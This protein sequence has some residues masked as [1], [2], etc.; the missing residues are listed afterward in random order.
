MIELDQLS[1]KFGDYTAVNALSFQAKPGEIL[2]FLGPNGAGK[3]TT[4]KMI[5]GALTPTSGRAIMAGHDI[6]L[7]TLQAQKHIG[8]LPEGA[9]AWA[10]M[11]PDKMLGFFASVR[12]LDGKAMERARDFAIERANLQGV[13]HQ[14]IDTLS[15]GFKRR[16][17]LAGAILHDPDILILDEPTDGLDPNQKFEVRQLIADLSNEKAIVIS[18]HILEEVDAICNRAMII[19]QGRLIADG[20]PQSLL[21]K[22]PKHLQIGL[23]TNLTHAQLK[24]ALQGLTGIK[25][26]EGSGDWTYVSPSESQDLR[27]AMKAH[28]EAR[29]VVIMEMHIMQGRMDDVFRLLT[30]DVN[31][32]QAA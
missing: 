26:V 32:D 13:R 31:K 22:D 17:G 12:G 20:T 23:K 4:M 11:T 10:D 1:K 5:T 8:Y 27:D 16:V 2:G 15:K 30:Q 7:E 28:L 29:E 19:N 14:L 18:T 21:E 25:S 6:E 3:S 24:S 9:P